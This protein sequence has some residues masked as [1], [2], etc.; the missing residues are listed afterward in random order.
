[1]PALLIVLALSTQA[2]PARTD[3]DLVAAARKA[4]HAAAQY[5]VSISTGGGYLWEYSVDL[6]RRWGEGRATETQIW[7]QPPGTP[8]IGKALLNAYRATGDIYI[9]RAAEAAGDALVWGQLQCGGWAYYIDFSPAGERKFYYAHLEGRRGIDVRRLR[10]WGVLDDNN[11]QEAISFLIQLSLTSKDPV[12]EKA[13]RK[14]LEWLLEAQRENGGWPQVYPPVGAGYWNYYTFND[15]A[16]NDAIRVLL[17]GW[18]AYKD[19]RYLEAAKRGG[20]FIIMTQGSADQPA[21]AQQYDFDLQ[22]AWARRFEPPAWCSAVVGRN[23]RTLT[24][25][26]LETGDEKYLSPIPAAIEWVQRSRLPDGRWARF[27]ELGSNRP[28]YFTKK[29]KLTYDPSDCPTHYS[30]KSHYGIPSAINYYKEVVRLGREEYLH[31]RM[32]NRSPERM[33][34][35]ARRMARRVRE[36]IKWQDAQGRWARGGRVRMSDAARNINLLAD[37]VRVMAYDYTN[38]ADPDP[39]PVSPTGWLTKIMDYAKDRIPADKLIIGLPLYAYEW[40]TDGRRAS[41]TYTQVADILGEQTEQSYIAS[42]GESMSIYECG[43]HIQC[44]MYFQSKESVSDH[45]DLV[46]SYDIAGVVYW[47]LGGDGTLLDV[48]R[49]YNLQR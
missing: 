45:F 14:G 21:W 47:R 25:L 35:W 46:T 38:T 40:G 33:R 15:G 36:V 22:P 49:E 39:G 8:T 24:D 9:L 12:F 3:G 4:L 41:Y 34:E 32:N 17:E 2:A 11:S 5:L 19:A 6:K 20:D 43:N 10:N 7:V 37:Y 26:Y 29:Y 30:F 31:K 48:L 42:T 23:I 44:T 28:L 18:R 27:Y 1:M 13:A 16:I